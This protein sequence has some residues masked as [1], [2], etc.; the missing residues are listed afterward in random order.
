MA[1]MRVRGSASFASGDA[2]CVCLF[3]CVLFGVLE[4]VVKGREGG[5]FTQCLALLP[6][7]KTQSNVTVEPA[8]ALSAFVLRIRGM[9]YPCSLD[10]SN[11]RS[12]PPTLSMIRAVAWA[13][14]QLLQLNADASVY[15][16]RQPEQKRP[17]A[18]RY[19]AI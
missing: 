10:A 2:R 12:L 16:R 7:R 4:V 1:C 18:R 5:S 15:F 6:A 14:E 11:A 19:V 17:A 9:T 8:C 13:L 3:V